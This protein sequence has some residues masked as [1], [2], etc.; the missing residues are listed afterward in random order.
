MYMRHHLEVL[1]VVVMPAHIEL[2][3]RAAE[4]EAIRVREAF[5]NCLSAS[6]C[7]DTPTSVALTPFPRAP[8][9]ALCV[10]IC[11]S[12]PVRRVN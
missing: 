8:L 2:E 11:T 3:A 7:G 6:G 12:V 10:S 4:E 5:T 9:R 1:L